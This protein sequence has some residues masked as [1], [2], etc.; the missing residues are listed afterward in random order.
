MKFLLGWVR[1]LLPPLT[2]T[3][4]NF[5]LVTAF[6]GWWGWHTRAPQCQ[7]AFAV[8]V[9]ALMFAGVGGWYSLRGIGVRR[10]RGGAITA[11][12]LFTIQYEIAN[13]KFIFPAFHLLVT[14]Y[15]TNTVFPATF[16]HFMAELDVLP[17]GGR[18]FATYSG[19][20]RDR[21]VL[22]FDVVRLSTRF[23]FGLF[24]FHRDLRLPDVM[25][26]HPRL[27][28]IHRRRLLTRQVTGYAD[29]LSACRD[30]GYDEFRGLRDYRPGDHPRWIHWRWSARL[31]GRL[32]VREF[33]TA[34][35][36]DVF[37]IFDP[38]TGWAGR[39]HRNGKFELAVSYTVALVRRLLGE[40]NRVTLLT[41]SGGFVAYA[42]LRTARDLR[43]V[44]S[45]MAGVTETKG[46]DF[47]AAVNAHCPVVR[48]MGAGVV[49][50]GADLG[51]AYDACFGTQRL[52]VI[53]MAREKIPAIFAGR[54][55]P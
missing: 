44:L 49:V 20:I 43:R 7:A 2:Y 9:S 12:E 33:G 13:D 26:S 55:A 47:T 40:G 31:P 17:P 27:V 23:P 34:E 28:N 37:V 30:R 22:A 51:A 21:G 46:V 45:L 6:T 15:C 25:R 50:I 10:V 36:R 53:D 29:A 3:G 54:V 11:G 18:G 14:D 42:N 4:W 1:R 39:R 24:S 35:E 8:L 5:V 38:V 41:H 16:Y 19:R 48:R 52:Q 32:R